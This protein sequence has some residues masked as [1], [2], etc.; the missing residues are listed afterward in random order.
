MQIG[1]ICWFVYTWVHIIMLGWSSTCCGITSPWLSGHFE[2]IVTYLVKIVHDRE[3]SK[4]VEFFRAE[5]W[6]TC[7][8]VT[9]FTDFS[10]LLKNFGCY[11]VHI[12]NPLRKDHLQEIGCILRSLLLFG[13]AYRVWRNHIFG[14]T[15]SLFCIMVSQ[16]LSQ[17]GPKLVGSKGKSGVF[18]TTIHN[19]AS[20]PISPSFHWQVLQK[21]GNVLCNKNRWKLTTSSFV[22]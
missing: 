10:I 13:P 9:F 15:E 2:P 3:E 21:W 6:N 22:K 16:N 19:Q 20:Q 14:V 18:H 4:H 7:D 11:G 5:N 1:Y 8:S 12:L 17:Y